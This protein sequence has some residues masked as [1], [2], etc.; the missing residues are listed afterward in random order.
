MLK[1]DYQLLKKKKKACWQLIRFVLDL[2]VTGPQEVFLVTQHSGPQAPQE[3]EEAQGAGWCW[4]PLLLGA[5]PAGARQ[6]F[7]D[8][9]RRLWTHHQS[10]ATSTEAS[11]IN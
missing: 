9:C 5:A 8:S 1:L 11:T 4:A 10:R 3:N 6:P 2:L 7:P